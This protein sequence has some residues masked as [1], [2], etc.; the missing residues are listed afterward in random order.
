MNIEAQRK[1]LD[2]RKL[3][4]VWK[5]L[6]ETAT[7]TS[8]DAFL[9][10]AS[11]QSIS[12]TELIKRVDCSKSHTSLVTALLSVYGRGK[13]QGLGLIN[14]IE[15]PNDRR[16]KIITLTKKGIQVAEQIEAILSSGTDQEAA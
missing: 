15:D 6:D 14:I 4:R 5:E 16:Y 11:S 9:V 1:L 13:K 10:I 7:L 12:M 2:I 8:I 3:F